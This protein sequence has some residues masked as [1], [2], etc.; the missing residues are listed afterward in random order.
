MPINGR[1]FVD[2]DADDEPAM[3]AAAIAT[4]LAGDH[5][6]AAFLATAAG[7]DRNIDWQRALAKDCHHLAELSSDPTQFRDDIAGRISTT[8]AN[9]KLEPTP[10][11]QLLP[12]P[13]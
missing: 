6:T 1:Q 13:R 12:R 2:L 3:R 9:L 11:H 4:Q 10:G 5:A 8:R 7:L